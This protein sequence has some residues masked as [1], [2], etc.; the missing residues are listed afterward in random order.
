MERNYERKLVQ[1]SV[2]SFNVDVQ[3]VSYT[4]LDVYK[5]QI[6]VRNLV[7]ISII[8][9]ITFTKPSLN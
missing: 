2:T 3:A 1:K 6:L 7:V 4:H 9:S 5:R 8:L